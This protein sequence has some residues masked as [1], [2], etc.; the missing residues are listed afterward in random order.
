P[1]TPHELA[2]RSKDAV[3]NTCKHGYSSCRYHTVERKCSFSS[4]MSREM[5]RE[6]GV[7][8]PR[9]QALAQETGLPFI[10]TLGK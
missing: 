5:L 3:K 10:T 8:S 9:T 7:T 2:P 1:T 6:A 4:E